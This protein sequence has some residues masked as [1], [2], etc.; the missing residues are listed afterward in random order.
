MVSPYEAAD[1]QSIHVLTANNLSLAE[2]TLCI[3]V[4]HVK[5]RVITP[6]NVIMIKP[7]KTCKNTEYKEEFN[8]YKSAK[9]K[10]CCTTCTQRA[11]FL[12]RK[13]SN[14][15]I[16][17][18]QKEYK[19]QYELLLFID[20]CAKK[21][22]KVELLGQIPPLKYKDRKLIDILKTFVPQ[23]SN[24]STSQKQQMNNNLSILQ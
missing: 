1:I 19:K 14:K 9:R 4:S 3:A 15:D 16:L 6:K 22:I 17:E 2:K 13:A 21:P 5:Q 10:Y 7:T 8:N 11:G 20:N 18:I 24:M 23:V 12:K